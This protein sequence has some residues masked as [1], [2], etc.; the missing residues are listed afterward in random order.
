MLGKKPTHLHITDLCIYV[1][2]N[3]YREDLTEEERDRLFSYLYW[4]IRS[5][6]S[7]KGYLLYEKAL[8]SFATFFAEQLWSRYTN[9]RQFT[10]PPT[11]EKIKSVL[12]YIRPIIKGRIIN[13]QQQDSFSEVWEPEQDRDKY[14]AGNFID[15]ILFKEELK[16]Y[17]ECSKRKELERD[18]IDEI[19]DLPNLV[20]KVCKQTKFAVDKLTLHRLYISCLL[21]FINHLTF[22]KETEDIIDEKIANEK[23][24]RSFIDR[25]KSKEI[26]ENEIIVWH[27]KDEMKEVI[28]VLVH[29]IKLDFLQEIAYIQKTYEVPDYA[30][31]SFLTVVDG[32][33]RLMYENN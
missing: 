11:L 1:D 8:D 22:F 20:Y 21:S 25:A 15:S 27:L 30:T 28:R 14:S 29:R 9:P 7:A 17:V 23:L 31:G 10:N 19:K 32:K 24:N 13:W 2:E 3:I 5:I 6:C 18:V 12:N 33:G 16:S 4:I 26:D